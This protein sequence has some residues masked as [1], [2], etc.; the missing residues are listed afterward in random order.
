MPRKRTDVN[1]D[2][3]NPKDPV[4]IGEIGKDGSIEAV[5]P[6][7][8]VEAV[9]ME[10]FMNQHLEI[11]VAQSPIKSDLPV[12]CPNVNGIN[13]PIVRG[14]R[15]LVKRKY[16]EALA[17][18][19]ETTYEQQTQDPSKPEQIQMVETTVPKY[20]FS[21]LMDPHPNGPEWLKSITDS[22]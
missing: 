20:P 13:Q 3:V 16:V 4:N 22:M 8:F 9:Q 10:E 1:A 19:A 11:M 15:V 12:I 2:S 6:N 5:S 7:D 21:V 14:R 18:C 17:R